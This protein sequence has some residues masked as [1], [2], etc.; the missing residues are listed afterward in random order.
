MPVVAPKDSSD[1]PPPLV[2]EDTHV[3]NKPHLL[4]LHLLFYRGIATYGR[5]S[6][7]LFV[8]IVTIVTVM[9]KTRGL[10]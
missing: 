4:K 8:T 2:A 5:Q 7:P 6:P 1:L 9:F 10:N 3:K